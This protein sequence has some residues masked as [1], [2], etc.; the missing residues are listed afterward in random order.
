MP[1]FLP[2]LRIRICIIFQDLDP[3]LGCVESRSV[4]ISYDTTKLTG[5][6]NLTKHTFCVGP[7]RPTDKENQVEMMYKKYCFRYIS[8]L[9]LQGSGSVSNS[10]NRIQL[11][12]RIWILINVK[13][14][15]R[16]RIKMVWIRNTAFYKPNLSDHTTF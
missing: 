14:R 10:R 13:S 5:R 6:E 9:N 3:F 1:N 8:S 2:V 15:I 16:V 11:K 4:S 7:V 12:S